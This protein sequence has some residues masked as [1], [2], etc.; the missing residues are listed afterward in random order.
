MT[1]NQPHD[2]KLAILVEDGRGE[3][4]GVMFRDTRGIAAADVNTMATHGRGLIGAVLGRGRA[5][6]LDLAPMRG[7]R[8]RIGRPQFLASVEA[9][10][11]TETG[12]SAHERA[13]TLRALG[14][15][16]STSASFQSPGHVFPA[17]PAECPADWQLSD[18]AYHWCGMREGALATAWC[19]I[20]DARGNVAAARW[21]RELAAALGLRVVTAEAALAEIA[22]IDAEPAL[23]AA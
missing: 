5:F 22:G 20:L 7:A 3:G 6:A 4:R 8:P 2:R 16:S 14:N 23:R 9:L 12:I 19:D 10:D 17:V 1:L 11:C 15:W 18:I 13:L 21:C